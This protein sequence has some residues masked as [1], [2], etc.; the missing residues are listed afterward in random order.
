MVAHAAILVCLGLVLAADWPD[1]A[2]D[3]AASAAHMLAIVVILVLFA[4]AMILAI[5]R[6]TPRDEQGAADERER[7]IALKAG[8]TAGTVLTVGLVNAIGGLLLGVN[9]VLIANLLLGVLIL[10]EVVRAG[11]AVASFRAGAPRA[12]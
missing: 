5:S 3:S 7:I 12:N 11:V 6:H 2:S 10:S 9:G 4:G 1:R 8:Q